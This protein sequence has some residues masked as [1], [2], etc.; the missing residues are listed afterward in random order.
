MAVVAYSNQDIFIV[1]FQLGAD[2]DSSYS[3]NILNCVPGIDEEVKPNTLEVLPTGFDLGHIV[4]QVRMYINVG[5]SKL[6]GDETQR[7]EY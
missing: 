5:G 3:G 1:G 6:V 2:I 4:S 7:F